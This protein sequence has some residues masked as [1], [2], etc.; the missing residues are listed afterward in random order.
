MSLVGLQSWLLQEG[1]RDDLDAII[2]LTVRTEL[3]NLVPEPA[4]PSAVA[5]D[6]PRLLLAG[7]ILARSDQRIDQEAALRIATAAISL[8]DDQALKDAGAV[9]LGKLSNYRAITLANDRHLLTA[10]LDR[11]ARCGAAP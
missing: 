8:T 5:I 2:R 3:D 10:G 4:A 6:W 1:I 11:T 9:L 7:S